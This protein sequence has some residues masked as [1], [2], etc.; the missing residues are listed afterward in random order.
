[1]I[2]LP[3]FRKAAPKEKPEK[4][5]KVR[6]L[7]APARP[8]GHAASIGA[9]QY[10]LSPGILSLTSPG[11]R[12]ALAMAEAGAV[13]MDRHVERGRRGL[14]VCAPSAGAG[15]T[16]TTVNLAATLAQAG[17]STIVIDCN[18]RRPGL[19]RFIRPGVDSPGVQ[20]FL[21]G[22]A[23]RVE[24]IIHPEV[25]PNLSLVYAGGAAPD[26]QELLAS[27]RLRVMLGECMRN[28][29]CTLVDTPPANQCSDALM[30]AATLGYAVIVAR[31]DA[32]YVTDVELLR[33]QLTVNGATV[34]GSVLNQA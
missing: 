34:V 27:P 17:V 16:F 31:R 11:S 8:A 5:K 20:Q 23:D 10:E 29:H 9:E 6:A 15:A 22:E 28:F 4:K 30:V 12:A 3:G 19:E 32:A 21:R 26:A 7:A 25:L 1:M 18:L 14:A 13:L 2:R 33:E 24:E